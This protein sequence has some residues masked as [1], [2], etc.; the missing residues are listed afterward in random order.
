MAGG[1]LLAAAKEFV[2]AVEG[3][4]EELGHGMRMLTEVGRW[5]FVT[6]ARGGAKA[7]AVA[8]ACFDPA[9]LGLRWARSCKECG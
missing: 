3:E 9:P 5:Q 8:A 7:A 1:E 4:R 2:G 6:R